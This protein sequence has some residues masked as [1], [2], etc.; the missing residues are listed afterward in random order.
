MY[1]GA[2]KE[3]GKVLG[4]ADEGIVDRYREDPRIT[5][6]GRLLRRVSL[7][8][9][10]QFWCVL[11]GTMSLVGPRPILVEEL[12]QMKEGH[13]YRHIARPGLTGLWQVSGRKEISWDQRMEMDLEYIHNWSP[14]MDA[15]LILRT[16]NAIIS[17]KGAY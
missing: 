7:D 9:T 2:D 12:P 11:I 3:R 15:V 5:P 14:S 17:G 8:E 13:S 16:L 10:P 6:V 4:T 1:V